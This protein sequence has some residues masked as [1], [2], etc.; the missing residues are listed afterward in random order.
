LSASTP[1]T[2]RH[3]V[4]SFGFFGPQGGHGGHG[5]TEARKPSLGIDLTSTIQR[6][7]GSATAPPGKP[8]LQ[9]QPVALRPAGRA[10]GTVKPN[11]LEVAI[12]SA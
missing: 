5:G 1:T 4:G 12:V 8:R 11:R 7:F 3:Y 2:D 10:E 6:V 9:I